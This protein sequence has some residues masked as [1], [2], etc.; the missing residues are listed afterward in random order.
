MKWEFTIIKKFIENIGDV[1]IK[2]DYLYGDSKSEITIKDG[3]KILTEG[4]DYDVEA[5]MTLVGEQEIKIKFKGNY[6][7]EITQKINIKVDKNGWGNPRVVNGV[8]HYVDNEGTTSVKVSPENIDTEG[9][10]WLQEGADE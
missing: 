8:T 10:I 2:K 1:T 3:E 7:G 4:E 9:I 6:A 5:D